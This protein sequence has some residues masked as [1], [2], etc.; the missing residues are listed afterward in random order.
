MSLK[1]SVL[2][3]ALLM[4]AAFVVLLSFSS[5][6]TARP[7]VA[8]TWPNSTTGNWTD[9]GAWS[10]GNV[11][12][13]GDD[14]SI[15]IGAVI[16]LTTTATINNL[17]MIG[18]TISGTGALNVTGLT[19]LNPF[20]N[21]TISTT[22]SRLPRLISSPSSGVIVNLTDP[23][24]TADSFNAVTISNPI[25][26]NG[27]TVFEVGSHHIDALV[28]Q[29]GNFGVTSDLTVTQIMSWTGGS[30]NAYFNSP[31]KFTLAS[32]AVMTIN[33]GGVYLYLPLIN[34]GTITWLGPYS[35]TAG[36]NGTLTNNGTLNINTTPASQVTLGTSSVPFT[37][38]GLLRVNALNNINVD[39][40]FFNYGQVELNSG[41]FN[42]RWNNYIQRAGHTHLAG[43]NLS[44]VSKCCNLDNY[45]IYLYG[46]ALSGS[47]IITGGIENNGGM[48]RLTGLLT[49]T[50]YY[51][52]SVTGTLQVTVT[53]AT[54]FGVM[55]VIQR[56]GVNSAGSINID[57]TLIVNKA[58]GFNPASG[59]RFQIMTGVTANGAFQQSTGNLAPAFGG[60]AGFGEVI[61]AEPNN[62]ALMQARPFNALGVRG[63]DNGYTIA[64][65]NPTT[66]TL[67]V[68]NV[69]AYIPISFTYK[70]T[71]TVGAITTNPIDFVL[72][73]KRNL[74]F[75]PGFTVTAGNR[76]DFSFGVTISN[77]MPVGS[78]PLS[79]EANTVVNSQSRL[80]KLVDVAPIDLPLGATGNVTLGGG[81]VITQGGAVS[82]LIPRSSP[83]LNV[84]V[85][86]TC[87]PTLEP[88]GNLQNVFVAQEV[89]GRGVF[90]YSLHLDPNQN[91]RPALG[92]TQPA[93][94][95]FYT[96]LIPSTGILP[97]VPLKLFPD[98]DARRPCIAYDFS[99][100]GIRPIGCVGGGDPLGTPQLY[101]P[102][103]IIR[104]AD[105]L[106]PIVGATVTLQRVP[107]ALP[108][109]P[110]L[111]RD[112][113]TIDT[114]PGGVGGVWSGT[115][116]GG[117]FEQPGFEPA[118][119]SPNVNPQ[120][121]GADGR[122]GWNV[123]TGCWYV[124]VSADGYAS[125]ISPLVGVPPE[126]T[127]L[128]LTLDALNLPNKVYLP[129]VL[130]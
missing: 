102:S 112:C 49:V 38:T 64:V 43:G 125:K 123:V 75:S 108:D 84:R 16:N 51:V 74:L 100:Y 53:G 30:L 59:D 44:G 124:T 117:I 50:N 24:L 91:P 45:P 121:T 40:D 11:P 119:I 28:M 73:G 63:G 31:A 8:C 128:D 85:R 42:M 101:D 6:V 109:T 56:N 104:D 39:Y 27:S 1:R 110:S 17:T 88:C 54:N 18:G 52:Q 14:V 19:N 15:G 2:C 77:V 116:G 114:R 99:G 94:Y 96:G 68:S 9:A 71:S 29:N 87:P 37:N 67:T 34:E 82:I 97:G 92:P 13:P 55:K 23:A 4:L 83:G 72:N 126:V 106:Q 25:G 21:V 60:Y 57:G 76:R 32:T 66:Q 90:S 46:G 62:A 93:D 111:T 26:S 10:C 103:G 80:V 89:N 5:R 79:V 122:Y 69:T 113:R 81:T 95:G 58:N 115:A 120:I 41:S 3:G 118:Q 107:S 98:W 7:T 20:V 48:V 61:V 127:D 35:F 105:T 129:L 86:I 78:Y 47:G 130:K 12:G 70:L 33:P 22:G 36:P 65:F